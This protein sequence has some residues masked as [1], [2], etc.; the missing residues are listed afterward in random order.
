MNP[1]TTYWTWYEEQRST[2]WGNRKN[3]YCYDWENL[4]KLLETKKE[5]AQAWEILVEMHAWELWKLKILDSEY[6]EFKQK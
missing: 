6:A 3:P 5:V 1:N 4:N 2:R